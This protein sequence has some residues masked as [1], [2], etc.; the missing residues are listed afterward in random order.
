MSD[1]LKI[2]KSLTL[3]PKALTTPIVFSE[4]FDSGN[5]T[6]N[7]WTV[8]NGAQTNSFIVGT[9]TAAS[10]LY[11]AYISNNSSSY[12]Y[13]TI[14]P[15]TVFFYKDILIPEN[16]RLRIAYKVTGESTFDR[17]SVINAPT[18]QTVT[19]GVPIVTVSEGTINFL[20]SSSTYS[21][22]TINLSNY[23]NQTRRIIFQWNNDSSGGTQPPISIDVIEIFEGENDIAVDLSGNLNIVNSGFWTIKKSVSNLFTSY[24]IN[25]GDFSSNSTNGLA[26]QAVN[27]NNFNAT[28]TGITVDVP[29]TTTV[30]K[31]RFSSN[32]EF[33][34]AGHGTSPY[35]NVYQKTGKSFVKIQNPTTLPDTVVEHIEWSPNGEFLACNAASPNYIRIYQRSGKTLTNL[36]LSAG[37]PGTMMGLAWSFNGEFLAVTHLSS[38][39]LTIYQR[40]GTTF[41][42]LA[43]P[44]FLPTSAD[45]CTWSHDNK[46]LVI[47]ESSSQNLI[48]YQRNGTTFSKITDISGNSSLGLP[49]SFS[50]DDSLFFYSELVYSHSNGNFTLINTLDA[51]ALYKL[52]VSWAKNGKYIFYV[53]ID[54]MFSETQFYIYRISKNNTIIGPLAY[55]V[56]FASYSFKSIDISP[57]GEFLAFGDQYNGLKIFK[58][59][60]E[61][62]NNT[63]LTSPRIKRSG[64]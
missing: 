7:G 31:C 52:D 55:D 16:A 25:N 20:P 44:S 3:V 9:A 49:I 22:F 1:T 21:N 12:Q 6:T 26:F 53:A 50:P 48:V 28:Q 18:T 51:G 35:L 8:V 63:F 61:I 47:R 36:S 15:S 27:Y 29:I 19:A 54:D 38:P 37:L 2:K 42:K 23:A 5:F 41:T 10:G 39:Y 40:S 13:T 62:A 45:T 46:F 17:A 14:S 64:T 60:N 59:A 32:G 4:N 58:I 33:L 43:N 56:G 24:Y 30:N 57:N 11:S 34:A